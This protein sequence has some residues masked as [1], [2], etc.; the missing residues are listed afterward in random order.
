MI[1]RLD[2]AVPEEVL[3]GADAIKRF[4]A[5][6]SSND[7]WSVYGLG[8]VHHRD[9]RIT[10]QQKEIERLTTCLQLAEALLNRERENR[11]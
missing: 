4:A 7:D 9:A 8:P 11:K 10:E 5:R 6:H 1:R 2:T 3:R